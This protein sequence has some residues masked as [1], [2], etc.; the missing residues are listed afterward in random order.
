MHDLET[1]LKSKMLDDVEI[2]LI[3]LY[4]KQEFLQRFLSEIRDV[5]AW[6]ELYCMA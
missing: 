2:L 5:G 1:I 3:I 6:M 4:N